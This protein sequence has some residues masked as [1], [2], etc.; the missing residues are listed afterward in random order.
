M[1]TRGAFVGVEQLSFV[2]RAPV[3]FFDR[4]RRGEIRA[5]SVGSRS[6]YG[7]DGRQWFPHAVRDYFFDDPRTPRLEKVASGSA[8]SSNYGDV[9]SNGRRRWLSAIAQETP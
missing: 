6:T 2:G 1:D 4:S 9:L 5:P 3:K 8:I 7:P